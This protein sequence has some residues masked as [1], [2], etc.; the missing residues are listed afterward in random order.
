MARGDI[1]SSMTGGVAANAAVTR[2]PAL[3]V[4]EQLLCAGSNI[5]EGTAPNQTP[6][7]NASLQTGTI[8]AVIFEGD[9]G[10]MGSNWGGQK[11]VF[12][13]AHYFDLN[14]RTAGAA[15]LGFVVVEVG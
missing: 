3:G 15:T 2:Q 7:V 11:M 6:A 12:T 13:N 4:E 8:S 10:G 5:V 1:T 9:A 14:N